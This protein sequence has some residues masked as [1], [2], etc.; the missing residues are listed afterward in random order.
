[1]LYIPSLSVESSVEGCYPEALV[2]LRVDLEGSLMFWYYFENE[3][4]VLVEGLPAAETADFL[5]EG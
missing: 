2:R 5:L 4:R 3:N 1:V